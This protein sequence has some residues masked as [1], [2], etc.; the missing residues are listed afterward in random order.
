MKI[1]AKAS[2]DLIAQINPAPA[3][4]LVQRRIGPSLDESGELRPLF[5]GKLRRTPSVGS[6]A[7]P[8]QTFVIIAVH[9]VPQRLPV[10]PANPGRARNGPRGARGRV[11]RLAHRLAIESMVVSRVKE[12]RP[13]HRAAIAATAAVDGC[14]ANDHG[15]DRGQDER[16]AHA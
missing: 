11:P 10:H 8:G 14:A 1:D 9:P 12:E 5:L 4:D 16:I 15:G 6:I 7:Q 2:L 13:D 3:N